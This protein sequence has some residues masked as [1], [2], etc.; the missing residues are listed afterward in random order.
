MGKTKNQ[1]NFKIG[2]DLDGVI[3]D[4]SEIRRRLFGELGYELK[5][6]Q[7]A[8]DIL[9]TTVS[10][11]A[12]ARVQHLIFDDLKYGLELPLMSG[13]DEILRQLKNQGADFYLISRRKIPETA[14]ELLKQKG[15][16]PVYFDNQNSF[17]VN[18]P[19]DKN[20]KAREIGITHYV[21]DEVAVLEKLHSVPN[22]FLFDPFDFS[23]NDTQA[24]I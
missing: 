17:F 5:L 13:V 23:S 18:K 9:R 4:F 19:E 16:W 14:I 3:I 24:S 15:F 8:S 20:L 11:E 12:R 1:Y 2:L 21:D 6:E 22:R 10:E 7:A